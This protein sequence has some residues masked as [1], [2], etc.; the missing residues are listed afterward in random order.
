M[1]VSMHNSRLTA[2]FRARITRVETREEF[3]E[4]LDEITE[5][6]ERVVGIPE[7]ELIGRRPVA[8]M[9]A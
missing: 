6:F 8:A 3:H 9:S 4:I 7:E 5:H 1:E 2:Q